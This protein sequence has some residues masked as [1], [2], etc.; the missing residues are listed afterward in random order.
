VPASPALPFLPVHKICSYVH[1]ELLLG[2]QKSENR[3]VPNP[4]NM[5]G[6]NPGSV[7]RCDTL[8]DVGR[9]HAADTSQKTANH[10][11]LFELLAQVDAEP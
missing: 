9:Y 5:A 7:A 4:V 8:Y 6:L 1:V 2:G 3:R 10:G 11:V